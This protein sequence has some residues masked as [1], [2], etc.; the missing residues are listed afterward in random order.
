MG[1]ANNHSHVLNCLTDKL[2]MKLIATFLYAVVLGQDDEDRKVPPRTPV[3]RMEQLKRHIGRLMKDHFSDCSKSDAWEDKLLKICNR[4]LNA[5]NLRP[6]SCGFFDPDKEHGGPR[7][8]E[9]DER[10]SETDA[11]A[12]IN[13]ITSG[14]RKWSQRYLNECGG[15]KNHEHIVNHSNKWRKKLTAKYNTGC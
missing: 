15:Q 6:N 8:E 3:A 14:I 10:Y 5:Y 2:I 1:R 9:E 12:S 11:I 4:S 13:G 7:A